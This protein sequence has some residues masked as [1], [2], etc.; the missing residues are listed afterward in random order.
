VID[1]TSRRI[2]AAGLMV[3]TAA[4]AVLTTVDVHTPL[5]LTL[6]VAFATLA[7]GWAAVAYLG[8]TP[9]SL[10]WIT[11]IAVSISLAILIAQIMVS[12]NWW[13]PVGALLTLCGLTLIALL[14]HLVREDERPDASDGPSAREI[15][16]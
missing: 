12:A 11:S 16:T 3:L 15:P 2:T 9:S 7:P 10:A 1:L 6:M 8:I 4:T 5:R 14:P 13:H